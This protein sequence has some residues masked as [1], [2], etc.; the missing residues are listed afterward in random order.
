[1]KCKVQENEQILRDGGILK[2]M[3]GCNVIKYYEVKYLIK[4]NKLEYL[5]MTK[6]YSLVLHL[7]LRTLGSWL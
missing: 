6:R 2:C 4:I 5:T 7:R 1:M 3:A